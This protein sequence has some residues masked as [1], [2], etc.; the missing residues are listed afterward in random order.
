M[1]EKPN[2]PAKPSEPCRR[3]IVQ[4]L[5]PIWSHCDMTRLILC[6]IGALIAAPAVAQVKDEYNEELGL[7][8]W[9]PGRGQVD[10]EALRRRSL[11]VLET[12]YAAFLQATSD[13]SSAAVAYCD[14]G[15]SRADFEQAFRDTWLAW[16][17]LDSYQFGPVEINGAAL[18]VNFWPDKKNF[19][20]RALRD[21]L[22]QP[23]AAQRD[24]AVIAAGSAAAQGLP[25]IELLLYT[26][27]PECPAVIGIS[28]YLHAMAGTLYD[29]WFDEG[30]WADL[31]RAAGP[32][33]PVYLSPAEFTK[34]LYTAI[35]FGLIR[36]AD[37]RLGRPLGTFE[38]SFP[39]RAEAWRSGL[40]A[41]IIEAQLT[42]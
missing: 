22:A 3:P 35:D 17:P 1:A 24:P 18:A 38:R 40:T 8:Y 10:H 9:A 7:P 27:A 16:A 28:G 23:D 14:A 33:N 36:V 13:L 21:L 32:D 37:Q 25:A 5:S 34:T 15:A 31:A 30:G 19:V 39:T 4:P 2:P 11:A 41:D 26:D 29:D 20:G 6:L 42:G 12:Q